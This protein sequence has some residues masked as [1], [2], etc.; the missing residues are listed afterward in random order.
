M[1]IRSRRQA[2]Q[3]SAACHGRDHRS[4]VFLSS[5]LPRPAC[6][7]QSRVTLLTGG[8]GGYSGLKAVTAVTL[9]AVWV[10]VIF[11]NRFCSC[12]ARLSALMPKYRRFV[13]IMLWFMAPTVDCCSTLSELE[14]QVWPNW[15]DV[16]S[17]FVTSLAQFWG[18]LRCCS[19]KY[20]SA[21]NKLWSIIRSL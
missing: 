6:H 8:P 19:D 1:Y 18:P 17:S 3:A 16:H 12:P 4:R 14:M 2:S 20:R 10:W 13:C 21:Y 15:T 7:V 9:G 11:K 5:R